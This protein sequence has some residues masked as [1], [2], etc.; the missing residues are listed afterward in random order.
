MR[1]KGQTSRPA[2][3]AKARPLRAKRPAKDEWPEQLTFEEMS[4]FIQ[5]RLAG[6]AHDRLVERI[7]QHEERWAAMSPE[8]RAAAWPRELVGVIDDPS[9]PRSTHFH[10]DFYGEDQDQ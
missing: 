8:A 1:A 2:R 7:R 6:P 5:R 9:F 4:R 10:E 3:S